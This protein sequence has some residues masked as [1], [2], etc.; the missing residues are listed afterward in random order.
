MQYLLYIVVTIVSG[1]TI[2]GAIAFWRTQKG[3]AKT[4]S[5]LLQRASALQMLAVILIILAATALRILDLINPEA[6]VS[7]LSGVAGTSSAALRGLGK[8]MRSGQIRRTEAAPNR[9]PLGVVPFASVLVLK[10]EAERTRRRNQ[11][12]AFGWPVFRPMLVERWWPAKWD[13]KGTE[14]SGRL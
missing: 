12:H 5:L 8:E 3:A 13:T 4:F 11:C 7:I 6:V 14:M 1:A 2:V 10:T 9:K